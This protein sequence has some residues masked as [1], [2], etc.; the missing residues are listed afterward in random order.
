VT[1]Q[2]DNT[3]SVIDAATNAVTATIPVGS[4]PTGVAADPAAATIYVTNQTPGSIYNPGTVS[5]IDAATSTV[6]ATIPVDSFPHAVAVDPAAGTIYM[7]SGTENGGAVS[8]IDA[9]TN[10]VTA[11]ITVGYRPYGVAVD[12]AAGTVYVTNWDSDSVS[13]IDAAARTV[14][15]TIFPGQFPYGVAV[16][17]AAG[18]V[19]VTN[20]GGGTCATACVSVIDAATGAVTAAVPVGS[21]PYGVAVDPSTHTAYVAN[22]GDGTVSVISPGQ[23]PVITSAG[24]ATIGMRSPVHFTVNTSGWPSSCWIRPSARPS[25]PDYTTGRAGSPSRWP[26]W[27]EGPMR[28]PGSWPTWPA[29]AWRGGEVIPSTACSSSARPYQDWKLTPCSR[30]AQSASP[31]S[32]MPGVLLGISIALVPTATGLSTWPAAPARSATSRLHSAGLPSWTKRWA[33][34][35]ERWRTPARRSTWREPPASR[36]WPARCSSTWRKSRQRK[37]ARKIASSMP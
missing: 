4:D 5:V 22:S 14:S 25:M 30:R 9:A 17:P 24:S 37:A 3:V 19:Y 18:T 7:T 29:V 31:L 12:P 1:N 33:D 10:A 13:V 26:A 2:D 20:R 27:P 11:T 36:S 34:G 6:T 32:A 8:V 15:A 35:R 23:A 28:L 16:D 21:G